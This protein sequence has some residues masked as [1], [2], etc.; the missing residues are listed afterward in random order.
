MGS[1][2]GIVADDAD[3]ADFCGNGEI[4]V[5]SKKVFLRSH[6]VKF[7]FQN[8]SIKSEFDKSG[9]LPRAVF[10]FHTGSIKRQFASTYVAATHQFR[11][12]TGSIKSNVLR[13]H[14]RIV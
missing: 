1:E 12:H 14:T 3:C 9:K 5:S 8:G 6:R 13:L 11:F 2:S 7:R 4:T 10:R